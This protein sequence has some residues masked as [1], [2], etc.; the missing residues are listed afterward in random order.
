MYNILITMLF[1]YTYKIKYKVA[2]F[3]I[4]FML[5]FN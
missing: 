4:W 5:I 2:Q 1:L 3:L